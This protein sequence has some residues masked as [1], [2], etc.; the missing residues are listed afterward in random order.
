M[1]QIRLAIFI[2]GRGSNMEAILDSCAK[3]DHPAEPVL[4]MSNRPDAEGLNTAAARGINAAAVDHKPFGK[5]REAFERAMHAHLTTANVELIALAGF[6]RIL[7]P[8]FVEKWTGRLINIHPSLL[9]KYPGL[10]THA[11]A[12]AAGDA[13]HGCSVHWVTEGVDQGA[14]IDQAR[15]PILPEDTEETLRAR[16]LEQE[17]TLYPRALRRA[18][19]ELLLR[20]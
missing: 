2:S 11:R 9:P 10:K 19:D 14:V 3:S 8:W 20:N 1:S 6:M 4:I 16:V 7:T 5:D 15:I 18:C 13:E 17:H 12:L